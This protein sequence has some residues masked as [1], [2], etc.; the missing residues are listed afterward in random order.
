MY[1][2]VS[3]NDDDLFAPAS[4][5]SKKESSSFN[6]EDMVENL[7]RSTY[8]NDIE[9]TLV[10]AH[11]AHAIY[12]SAH[13]FIFNSSSV[14][15]TVFN[16]LNYLTNNMFSFNAY[17]DNLEETIS[18]RIVMYEFITSINDIRNEDILAFFSKHTNSQIDHFFLETYINS[19]V[20]IL[21]FVINYNIDIYKKLCLHISREPVSNIINRQIED[22]DSSLIDSSE[23][24]SNIISNIRKGLGFE[25]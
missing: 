6:K 1:T 16:T 5:S 8:E 7:L 19:T 3:S 13:N 21:D 10:R 14:N 11:L 24:M 2:N 25:Y 23:Y 22:L 12:D 20:Q 4:E 18:K 9:S 15:R 17:A